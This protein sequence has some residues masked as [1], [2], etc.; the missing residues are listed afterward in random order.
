MV[1]YSIQNNINVLKNKMIIEW[2]EIMEAME[3]L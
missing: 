3:M 1:D 2:N